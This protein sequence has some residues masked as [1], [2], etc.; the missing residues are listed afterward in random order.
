MDI[1][2]LLSDENNTAEVRQALY[3][4]ANT[5]RIAAR[6]YA[7]ASLGAANELVAS[8]QSGAPAVAV[9][10]HLKEFKEFREKCLQALDAT[11]IAAHLILQSERT[12][13][14]EVDQINLNTKI[15]DID[16]PEIFAM[17]EGAASRVTIAL[18]GIPKDGVPGARCDPSVLT[19]KDR[20]T[21]SK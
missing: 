4:I 2:L 14:D 21:G 18:P 17:L 7:H 20:Q 15:S 12:G 9:W 5:L 10:P 1:N 16:S 19:P 11:A 3:G 13:D 8:V 6:D